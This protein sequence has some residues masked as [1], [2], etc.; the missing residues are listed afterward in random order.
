MDEAKD[1]EDE[2]KVSYDSVKIEVFNGADLIRT[3]KF[4]AP[5][6]NGIHRTYWYLGEK[7]V[8]RMRR[9]KANSRYEPRGVGVLPGMYKVRFSFGDQMDSTEVEVRYDPRQEFSREDM[10]ARYDALKGLEKKY[11]LGYQAVE[12]LKEALDITKDFQK[13]LSEED[14]E[15]YKEQIDMCKSASDTLN[16]MLDRFLGEQDDRQGITRGLPNSISSFYSGAYQYTSNGLH[17]PG[18]TERKLIAR[19]EEEL[20]EGLDMVNGYFN[21]EWPEYRAEMEKISIS[22]FEDYEEIK[23]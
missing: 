10:Q 9:G 13:K 8:Q 14:K 2:K 21:E 4:K 20:R 22:P 3:L 16:A 5:K 23:E 18:E 12:R 15:A 1:S 6:E 7:G 11:E 19:F 17:A